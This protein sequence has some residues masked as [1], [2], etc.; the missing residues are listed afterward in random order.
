MISVIMVKWEKNF[1]QQLKMQNSYAC[2]LILMI[3]GLKYLLVNFLELSLD[4]FLFAN[5][6]QK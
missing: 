3:K 4:Y 6:I 5:W 2:F 1:G